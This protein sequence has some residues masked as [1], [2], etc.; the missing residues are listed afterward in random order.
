MLRELAL[1]EEHRARERSRLRALF[2][3]S[4]D[5]EAQ[6]WRLTREL[7]EGTMPLDKPGLVEHLRA[8]VVN[9]VAIDQPVYSGFRT[10][11]ARAH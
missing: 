10:A 4:D 8:T 2:G 11:A 3:S 5:L 7:R 9:Q 6:R 1:G